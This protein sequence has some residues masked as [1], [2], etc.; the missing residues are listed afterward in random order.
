L[1]AMQEAGHGRRRG[2]ELGGLRHESLSLPVEL[3]DEHGGVH[4]L[5]GDPREAGGQNGQSRHDSLLVMSQVVPVEMPPALPCSAERKRDPRCSSEGSTTRDL[6]T[7]PRADQRCSVASW[8][9]SSGSGAHRSPRDPVCCKGLRS[10]RGY[11]PLSGYLP[12]R[13]CRS[14][15]F[16]H[17]T[18]FSSRISAS[19]WSARATSPATDALCWAAWSLAS[20]IARCPR[21]ARSGYGS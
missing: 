9:M 16:V 20:C 3:E 2:D 5:E 19:I 6:C 1:V 17:E 12:D 4:L 8:A 10:W 14:G 18:R 15:S 13:L 21:R 7:G 11:H